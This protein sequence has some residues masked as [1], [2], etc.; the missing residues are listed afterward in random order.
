MIE[1][2]KNSLDCL[3]NF[4]LFACVKEFDIPITVRPLSLEDLR[5]TTF[6]LMN[7]Q[8]INAI[9]EDEEMSYIWMNENRIEVF[10]K[11]HEEL[12]NMLQRMLQARNYYLPEEVLSLSIDRKTYNF[13]EEISSSKI[14]M[15]DMQ[16]NFIYIQVKS[17]HGRITVEHLNERI[18]HIKQRQAE[19]LEERKLRRDENNIY[20]RNVYLGQLN[21]ELDPVLKQGPTERLSEVMKLSRGKKQYA[22]VDLRFTDVSRVNFDKID[23]TN[24]YSQLTIEQERLYLTPSNRFQRYTLLYEFAR[25]GNIDDLDCLVSEC[26]LDINVQDER[27]TTALM[28]ACIFK[29][30]NMVKH[31][32]EKY[33]AKHDIKTPT[34]WDVISTLCSVRDADAPG[35]V[36]A[37]SRRIAEFLIE[38]AGAKISVHNAARIGR[39]DLLKT[40]SKKE[41]HSIDKATECSVAH[42]ASRDNNCEIL[43]YLFDVKFNF[44]QTHGLISSLLHRSGNNNSNNTHNNDDENEP[45]DAKPSALWVAC[46]NGCIEAAKLIITRCPRLKDKS[47]RHLTPVKIALKQGHMQLVR[48]LK[49]LGVMIDVEIAV[50]LEDKQWIVAYLNALDA[51]V[52]NASIT[53][54]SSSTTNS[55]AATVDGT[56]VQPHTPSA[57]EAKEAAI[58]AAALQQAELRKKQELCQT[59][60]FACKYRWIQL[61]QDLIREYDVD[62]NHRFEKEYR[63]RAV[64]IV[65]SQGDVKLM[66]IFLEYVN[67]RFNLNES[68]PLCPSL[69]FTAINKKHWDILKML[70][71]KKPNLSCTHIHDKTVL[72]SFLAVADDAAMVSNTTTTNS[73]SS[74]N[75]GN[76]SGNNALMSP[77]FIGN[78]ST[79]CSTLL[80]SSLRYE[81]VKQMLDQ[82]ASVLAMD[83]FG[84]TP[85]HYA[86]RVGD[87][88][89]SL[90]LRA[91]MNVKNED[92]K[93]AIEIAEDNGIEVTAFRAID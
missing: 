29:Q 70:L 6:S 27:G 77:G 74:N 36:D 38:K 87:D 90:I 19:I 81:I 83:S 47:Y 62:L 34:G 4:F 10:Q 43:S 69:I 1:E 45:E 59:L 33:K 72:H 53:T 24:V 88:I 9:P 75:S 17:E 71:D 14:Y 30:E 25:T 60:L 11:T 78:N 46:E 49:A 91:F 76:N 23:F 18:I 41:L 22:V 37:I 12:C 56:P 16:K 20:R 89:A 80:S 68:H 93:S 40:F 82:G 86:A 50:A 61:V 85:L 26:V 48:E 57:K 66:S 35:K 44:E 55:N 67:I 92:K 21:A 64:D 54:T 2:C 58:A 39:V 73:N 3:L 15:E 8:D 7:D 51:Q 65:C 13:E 31:L 42:I 5:R 63:N 32:I 52:N 28:H 79:S 84:N